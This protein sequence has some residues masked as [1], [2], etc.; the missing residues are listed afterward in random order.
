MRYYYTLCYDHA[1]YKYIYIYIYFILTSGF[2]VIMLV[3]L[4]GNAHTHRYINIVKSR[5]P[6]KFVLV[7]HMPTRQR[8]QNI[9]I[10]NTHQAIIT[11]K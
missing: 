8:L 1:I 11:D 4:I 7:R 5:R 6:E 3:T 2:Y 10:E 9:L